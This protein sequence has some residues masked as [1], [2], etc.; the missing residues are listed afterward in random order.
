MKLIARSFDGSGIDVTAKSLTP[1]SSKEVCMPARRLYL[2]TVHLILLSCR[3]DGAAL[4][5]ERD[6]IS[7]R[8]PNDANELRT[9]FQ[10][11][12]AGTYRLTIDGLRAGGAVLTTVDGKAMDGELIAAA[13]GHAASTLRLTVPVTAGEH[14]LVV[15]EAAGL[16]F[17]RVEGTQRYMA[18]G[19]DYQNRPIFVL[20]FAKRDESYPVELRFG[21]NLEPFFWFSGKWNRYDTPSYTQEVKNISTSSSSQQASLSFEYV[22]APKN[23]LMPTTFILERDSDTGNVIVRVQQSLQ[24]TGPCQF[25]KHDNI[26]FLHAVVNPQYGRDWDDDVPDYFWNREQVDID[27]D[28]LPGTRTHFA[29]MDDN[30]RRRFP[31]HVSTHDPSLTKLSFEHHTSFGHPLYAENT[32]GGW[33]TKSGVG[34]VGLV[35]RKYRANFVTGISPIHSHCGDGADTHFYAGW[36]NKALGVEM[37]FPWELK[38]DDRLDVEYTLQCLPSEVL[39]EQIELINEYDLVFFGEEREATSKIVRWYGD[40][41]ACGLL[42]SDGSAVILGIGKHATQYLV[43]AAVRPQVKGI[44]RLNDLRDCNFIRA[45]IEGRAD[46]LPRWVTIVDCG[47]AREGPDKPNWWEQ[48]LKEILNEGK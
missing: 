39:R 10:A 24:A 17:Y 30:S 38:K 34:C 44:F 32:I 33:F 4:G 3:F 13:D 37:F 15:R 36:A 1:A 31:F 40:K 22:H 5:D 28:T 46:V 23:L 43:P 9:T 18:S 21:P 14:Q 2:I 47:S 41:N 45:P 42:R 16:Q 12:E 35:I 25:G 7:F 19:T 8:L 29:L 11:E 6:E 48:R 26:E 27:N 20:D